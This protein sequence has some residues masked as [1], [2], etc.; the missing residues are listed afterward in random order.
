MYINYC[1]VPLLA[2]VKRM[3]SV[4]LHILL[5]IRHQAFRETQDGLSAAMPCEVLLCLRHSPRPRNR[6]VTLCIVDSSFR[7]SC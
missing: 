4:F 5:G 7:E 6:H 2:L 3:D 1:A